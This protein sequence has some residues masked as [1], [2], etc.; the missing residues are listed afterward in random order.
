MIRYA[1][2]EDK[3]ALQA[4]YQTCF[5]GE[6][7]FCRWF[8]DRVWQ[9]EHTILEETDGV[10]TS[11]LQMLPMQLMWQGQRFPA[12]YIYAAGTEPAFRGQGKMAALLDF[13]CREAAKQGQW[14]ST[15]ITQNDG[16]FDFYGRFGYLPSFAVAEEEVQ[17][18]EAEGMGTVRAARAED[19][20]AMLELY[21]QAA[22]DR[23]AI[24]R[25]P[26]DMALQLELYSE[27]CKV[28]VDEQGVVKA[29]C[30]IDDTL[31]AE[32][33][34][35][36]KK[37]LLTYCFRQEGV[38]RCRG[39]ALQRPA[40]RIGCIKPLRPEAE[41]LLQQPMPPFYLNLMFN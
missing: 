37:Q 31:A 34:G 19:I 23:L 40:P 6:P 20:P 30:F 10:M 41:A 4:L 22:Q 13:A 11:A 8:F 12:H 39:I 29:Y 14:Y 16:L 33:V 21:R 24:A 18:A 32:V 36:E 25:G 5:P 38:R 9:A 27:K 1:R 35:S 26:E 15:L 28:Y 7:E 3:A 17:P 2:Q